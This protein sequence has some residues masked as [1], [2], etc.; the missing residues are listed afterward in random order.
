MK[1][2][3]LFCN[4]AHQWNTLVTKFLRLH[5]RI[6]SPSFGGSY[7]ELQ[8]KNLLKKLQSLYN[9][10]ERM[11]YHV[12]IKIAGTALFFMIASATASAQ[13]WRPMGDKIALQ[14]ATSTD[15]SNNFGRIAFADL[16]G[17]GNLDMFV[18]TRMG[19][20]PQ[21]ERPTYLMQYKN[22]GSGNFSG[23]PIPV[24]ADGDTIK[25]GNGNYL[26]PAFADLD[27]DGNMDLYVGD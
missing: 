6:Q 12:G 22:D 11:Q 21:R 3:L 9:R 8:Q 1:R 16:D 5:K 7:S 27:E 15:N 26:S 18:G 13:Y 17:D 25:T 14:V 23:L 2:K 24:M 4:V 20:G 10:L 19:N